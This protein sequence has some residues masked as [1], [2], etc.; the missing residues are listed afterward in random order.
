MDL[1]AD[2]CY[3]ALRARDA[4]FD[5]HF[6]TAVRS[7]G[8]YCRPICPARTPRRENCIFVACA[9]AA[10]EL[11]YRPCLR[12]RPEASPGT[13]AWL[14]TSATV[15]RALRLIGDGALDR[16]SVDAFAARLG[17]GARQLRRLFVRHLGAPPIAVAE[18]RRLLF[19]KKLL[20]E[21]EMPIQ[22]LAF[23]AGFSS[24]RRFNAAF[25]ESYGTSPR[26]LRR[27]AP[28]NP[29]A[30]LLLRLPFRKPFHWN[31]LLAYLASRAVPGVEAVQDGRY[32]RSVRLGEA[33]GVVCVG[34]AN[35]RT[36]LEARIALS[37]PAPLAEGV[38]RL[39]RLFD[40]AADPGPIDAQLGAD[41]VLGQHVRKRPGL[42]VPGAWDGYEL[43]V[44]AILG[45]QISVRGA[46]TLAGR[47][48]NRHGERL[49][50]SLA[51]RYAEA[52]VSRLFPT[53][54]AIARTRPSQLQM[55]E[56]RSRALLAL[57]RATL[58]GEVDLEAS[59]GLEESTAALSALPGLGP[60]TAHYIAMR[61]LREPDAFPASDL[62]LRRALGS[63]G[64]PLSQR[65]L[66]ARAKAW[67]PWRA[68]AAVHLWSDDAHARRS[69][70]RSEEN[71]R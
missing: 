44:R 53:P 55:P 41:A 17:V 23:A 30:G 22:E 49:P 20:D 67:R 63:S 43:A 70:T 12:C 9:A 57:T 29:E 66:E 37:G 35:A 42:R 40:L 68:Y 13:P 45:Q 6:F 38:E 1:D 21:T 36:H 56:K 31:G 71:A 27:E 2:R 54:A 50:P 19:A 16:G 60:W 15:S 24:L 28:R 64:T 46:T 14:G 25:Q 5:G 62:G 34:M 61:A 47:I 10:A 11:G 58:G 18:T 32:L 39:R 7:T 26:A 3:R 59:R 69:S 48:A 4:R 33:V 65:V 51:A 8:I 52:G